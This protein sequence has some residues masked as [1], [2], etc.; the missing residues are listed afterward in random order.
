M[1]DFSFNALS[2]KHT[3]QFTADIVNFLNL[4]NNS[5]GV[6]YRYNY[7]TGF[8]DVPILGLASGF[9][10]NTPLYT[11]N[12]VSTKVYDADYS[13]SSTWGIQLG[14]RYNF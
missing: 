6:R 3:F 5:W 8:S 9:N 1:Q 13:T 12:P 10:R 11:F 4:V 7:G 14:L 2:K